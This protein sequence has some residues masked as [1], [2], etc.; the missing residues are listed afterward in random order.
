[1]SSKRSVIPDMR[2]INRQ[3]PIV[4]VARALDLRLDGVGKI[5][6]WH[7]D[8]HKNGD[9]TAS[10]GIRTV[11]NT[12]KCF[13]CD[14]KPMGP[15]DLVMDARGIATPADA[16]LWIAERFAVPSIPACKRLMGTE[17][18]RSRVGYERGLG[19]LIRSGLWARLSAPAQAIAPVLLE[20]G[21]KDTPLAESLRVRMAYRTLARFSGVQSHNAIRK[22]LVELEEVGF[23]VLPPSAPSRSLDRQ[24]ATYVVTPNSDELWELANT[25][26][27]Q[28][29]QEIAAEVELRRRQRNERLRSS[30]AD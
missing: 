19:L 9:R 20:H 13:G 4:Q 6:C 15:I 26:A 8:R 28:T 3:V 29:Q 22:G 2:Y 21:D 16:A 1:M 11:N 10:V 30:R 24:T 25:T 12:V 18:R 5:H 27:R 17:Q 23:V 7:A 14:S